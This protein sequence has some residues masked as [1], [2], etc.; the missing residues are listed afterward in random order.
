[1]NWHEPYLCLLARIGHEFLILEPEIT[2]GN[3]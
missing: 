3:Y 1:L 2:P